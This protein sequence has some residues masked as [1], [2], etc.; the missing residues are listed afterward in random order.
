MKLP[1]SQCH[2]RRKYFRRERIAFPRGTTFDMKQFKRS[3]SMILALVMLMSMV[4]LA[5]LP[6]AEAANAS[7]YISTTYASYLSVKT[8]QATAL[9]ESPTTGASAKY[10]LPTDT[11]LTVKALHKSTANTYWYEVLFY[12]MTLYVD[13]TATTKVS[14]L[15]GDV[16]ISGVRSPASLAYG[17]SFGIEGD[18]KS[19]YNKLGNITASM[20]LGTDTTR[21]AAL[22][23]SANANGKSY[24]LDGSTVDNSLSFGSLNPGVYTYRL[25]A[26]AVSYYIDD[27]DAFAT[28]TQTVVLN[29]QECVVTDWRNPNDDLAFGID[30]STW[31]GSIDWSQARYDID[32]AILRI[33][34]SE[35]LD[36]RF[37]EYAAACEKYDI[38]YGVYHYSYALSGSEATAE[39]EFVISTLQNN[40]YNPKLGVWFDMEDGTQAALANSTKESLVINFCDTIAAAGYLPGFYGFTSWFTTSFQNSY[41]SSI[42]VWIA[43]IDGFSSNGTATHDGGT[44][45]WQYSWEGSI[46]G[47]SGD[48]DCNLCYADFSIFNSDTTYL[49]N[50][51]KY[52]ARSK[53]KT[54]SSVTMRQYPSSSYSS[55]GTISSGTTVEIT[56]LYKNASNEYWYEVKNGNSVGYISASYVTVSEFLYDDIAIQNP[57]MA[58]NLNSGATYYLNGNLTSLYNNLSTVYARVYSGEDT[59]ASPQLSSSDNCNSKFYNLTDSTVCDN[60]VFSGLSSGYYTYE[61]SADV[62]NY[63]ISGG[64]LA[65]KSKNVVVW[66]APFTI[67]GAAITPP[68][69]MVCSHNVVTDPAVAATCTTPGLSAGTHCSKCNVVLTAQT[70][71]PATGHSYTASSEAANCQNYQLFHYTCTKCGHKYDIS[72][73]QLANWSETKPLG[74]PSNQIESKTQYRYATCTSSTWVEDSSKTLLYVNSWPSGFSTSSSLYSTYNKKSSKVTTSET[75]TSKIVVNSDKVVGYLYY[76]WCYTDSYYSTEYKNGS[77]TTFHAYYDTTSPS[78]YTCDTSDMSY[79]TSH[80][81]CSNS[82]WYF[83]AEVYGQNYT[84]YK[85]SSDGQQWGPWSAWSDT[86]YTPIANTRKVETRTVYRYTGATL[87]N[88]VMVNGSC[89]VCGLSCVHSYSGGF[90]TKCGASEPNKDYY[91]FGY[92]NGADYACEGDYANIGSY[93]FVNGKL[94]VTFNQ[95]SYVGVKTGDNANWYMTNGWQGEVSSATL[96]NTSVIGDSADKMWVPGNVEVTFTL[97]ENSDGTLTLSYSTSVCVHSTHNTSGICVNCGEAVNHTFV[98]NVCTGCG[99]AM[100]IPT[101]TPNY[102]TVSFQG[103]IMLNIYYTVANIGDLK[104]EDM[105]LLVF[106]TA[107]P[108]GTINTASSVVPGATVSGSKY[109]VHTNGISAKNLGDTL[110]FKVYAKLNDGSYIYSNMI[111]TSPKAYA[112]S[113]LKSTSSDTYIKSLCLAMLN[114]GAAAQQYFG[115]KTYD[116]MN[117][118]LSTTAQSKIESYNTSMMD[119]V[120]TA[121]GVKSA[122]FVRNTTAFPKMYPTVSFEGAF[123][124][125]YHFTTGLPVDNNVTMYYW[126]AD[127]YNNVSQLT[128]TNANGSIVMTNEGGVYRA[129]VSNISA[130]DMDSTIYVAGVYTSGG[131]T[132]TTGIISYSL[133]Q[134]CESIAG[135]SSNAAQDLAQKTA[136]Y[137]YYAERY[138][139]YIGT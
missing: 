38:P 22:S 61:I 4:Y 62:K 101:L 8:T 45:L 49:S 50:C 68:A 18:I 118:S 115:Y 27:S 2:L 91:L 15:T 1:Q 117:A 48:V 31:Q 65:S 111:S 26:E 36:N 139:D 53:G 52:P 97:V 113:L 43:Q 116:L 33:G 6:K 3:L 136:I 109:I 87:G 21:A 129:A 64:T 114:Y 71:I 13:A 32:F 10:T 138:F 70:T 42:P 72:A 81:T 123:S 102:P 130:K 133:G 135:N 17:Q 46:S 121:T 60:M 29:T 127:T 35:T 77:Y 124:I 16:S 86:V 128:R 9:R 82:N 66:T 14:H 96:Y 63:Y 103:A 75:T 73:D 83:V 98:D 56:G 74:V 92:I 90:C 5:P 93:L 88:H 89:S 55:M 119:D 84:T 126:T 95:T 44:W 40:G 69:Q 137:G 47:I 76:H 30:V 125:N 57:T 132:Y 131:T 105:G 120:V 59:Q 100:T 134:Y 122:A 78:N 106:T 85:P 108:N 54:T 67:G 37:L 34:F 107:Q 11:M 23:A 12:N 79:K 112:L 41:L 58:S 110:Y 7:S 51:T 25:T 39:A 20:H 94:T 28:S 99:K 19:T 24:S 104:P 80:S